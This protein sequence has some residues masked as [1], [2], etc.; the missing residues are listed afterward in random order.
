MTQEGA[1]P[2]LAV[3]NTTELFLNRELSWLE[4]NQRVLDEASDKKV[5]L[6]ERLKFLGICASNLD[7][8][9]MVRVAGLLEQ[10][11][12]R[13]EGN[14]PD[15]MTPAMQIESIAKRVTR[16]IAD[17]SSL[18]RDDIEPELAHHGVSVVDPETLKG[19]ARQ[20][21]HDYFETQ[22]FPVLTPLALDPGHPFPHMRNKDLQ[23]I[24][25]LAGERVGE[26]A[27]ALLQ[28][29]SVLPRMVA[30]PSSTQEATKFVLL[31]A[32]VAQHAEDLFRGFRSLGAWPFR[33]LRN[34]DLSID[35]EEAED[36]LEVIT[37]EV[38][39]RDRGNAVMLSVA[40]DCPPQALSMLQ[41][42]MELDPPFVIPSVAPLALQD[43]M[44]LGHPLRGMRELRD[45][46]AHGVMPAA[47]NDVDPFEAI[48]R[49]DVLLHHPYESFDPVVDFL[50]RA[51]TD[52]DV[53]AIK[54]TLYRTSGDSP[55]VAALIRAAEHG[56]HVVAL[57]EIKARFDE[58][59]NIHW[60]GKLEQ[61]GVHVVYGLVGLK[62]HC[63]VMLVVRREGGRLRRYVHLGTGNYNPH[64]ARLYTD[65]S[66]FTAR[67]AFGEDATALFN[68]LTSCTGPDAWRHL[69]VAPLGLHE[70][71]LGLIA[72]EAK[73]HTVLVPR[74]WSLI[75]DCSARQRPSIW[76]NR[77]S[78][79]VFWWRSRLS[80]NSILWI[81]K[82]S[83]S[84]KI[85]RFE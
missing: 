66:L 60:A 34:F 27:F 50:D 33:V 19:E 1:P 83:F 76:A 75:I 38:R 49:A 14:T 62:T 68:L 48:G 58:E 41:D 73:R 54:Q 30:L 24:V 21:L 26:P 13:I 4:F 39:R 16:L 84:T 80:K 67:E 11:V 43:M 10:R 40:H 8:F 9:F 55:V 36:L 31:E 81:R 23:L 7:E 59:N 70:R 61:A 18:F 46:P 78:S 32:L 51:A 53:L 5:P 20:W 47:L 82:R 37:E 77:A 29:P 15:G 17:M 28:V 85:R 63:K 45:P 35:E 44:G 56:K 22:V 42:A 2:S 57:V 64:T 72:R 25:M 3:E 65:L 79:R 52:P 12:E 74:W 69:V 71:V 6:L